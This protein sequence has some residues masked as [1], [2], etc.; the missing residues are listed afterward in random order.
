MTRISSSY[1]TESKLRR[2]DGLYDPDSVR[3]L[4]EG[5]LVGSGES[6]R[7]D[8]GR[9]RRLSPILVVV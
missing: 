2:D 4:F 1:N 8:I 3:G 5:V 6:L 7:F 9:R